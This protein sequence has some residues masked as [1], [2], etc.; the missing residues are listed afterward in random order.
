MDFQELL[1]RWHISLTHDDILQRW[2]EPHRKYHSIHHLEDLI[3]QINEYIEL[4]PKERDMLTLTA[5]FHDIIYNPRRGDNEVQSAEFFLNHVAMNK[6]SSEIKE[7]ATIIRDTKHHTPST[8]LSGIFSNMDM[9]IVRR[10]YAELLMWEDEIR[11]EYS[12]L[13]GIVYIIGRVR[14]LRQ[15]IKKYPENTDALRKLCKHLLF[16]WKNIRV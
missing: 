1:S 3:Q 4:S 5:I 12:H 16:P 2:N 9:A 15:M 14:F 11:Y 13:P 10:P 8:H 6:D 7:I